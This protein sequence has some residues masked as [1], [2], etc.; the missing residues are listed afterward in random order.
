MRRRKENLKR[1]AINNSELALPSWHRLS[2]FSP[3]HIWPERIFFLNWI[4]PRRIEF[5]YL[6]LPDTWILSVAMSPSGTITGVST[7]FDDFVIF[8]LF[9]QHI[10]K[11]S[12]ILLSPQLLERWDWLERKSCHPHLAPLPESPAKEVP[13]KCFQRIKIFS[14]WD[15]AKSTFMQD[16]PQ[17][18]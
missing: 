1:A 18:L 3:V 17:P 10:I 11:V 6:G 12:W 16:I 5:S 14:L 15:F 13:L 9:L 7:T 8:V 2:P 4:I